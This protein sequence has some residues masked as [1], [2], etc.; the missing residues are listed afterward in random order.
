MLDYHLYPGLNTGVNFSIELNKE[1]PDADDNLNGSFLSTL[2]LWD[3]LW[4]GE[5]SHDFLFQ[6][7]GKSATINGT[8]IPWLSKAVQGIRDTVYVL[9]NSENGTTDISKAVYDV[10]PSAMKI[11][12]SDLENYDNFLNT[13][14][15]GGSL[16]LK[17]RYPVAP[18]EFP[19][20]M[21]YTTHEL[22]FISVDSATIYAKIEVTESDRTTSWSGST[23]VQTG[24]SH[25]IMTEKVLTVDLTGAVLT[26]FDSEVFS[27]KLLRPLMNNA[28]TR[29]IIQGKVLMRVDTPLG[30]A[31]LEPI[32][33]AKGI[34]IAGMS[35]I[36]DSTSTLELKNVAVIGGYQKT[37]DKNPYIE[38]SYDLHVRNNGDA[39]LGVSL[40]MP[41]WKNIT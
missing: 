36:E 26:I 8:E 38:M 22:N 20:D 41:I 33:Y 11:Q 31:T 17:V 27:E 10:R 13:T 35:I 39:V 32:L 30:R 21:M 28:V 2:M 1:L 23:K 15:T 6:V 19:M 7:I 4:D 5:K 34:G 9:S 37:A 25:R 29:V 12:F 16:S 24:S 14:M 40:I 18:N 3:P